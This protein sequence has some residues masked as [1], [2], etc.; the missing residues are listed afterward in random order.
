[1]ADTE[2]DQIMTIVY[3]DIHDAV[4]IATKFGEYDK[5]HTKWGKLE[6]VLARLQEDCYTVEESP[7]TIKITW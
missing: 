5:S 3:R 4:K 2:F 1:M 7:N 6:E